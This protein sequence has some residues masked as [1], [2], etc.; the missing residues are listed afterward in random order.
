MP[1]PSIPEDMI[2]SATSYSIGDPGGVSRTEVA[3][4]LSRYALDWSRG[5][6]IFSV[7]MV[8]SDLQYQVWQYFY[9]HVIQKGAL[10]FLM[11]LDSDGTVVPHLVNILP[12][13]LNESRV[14]EVYWAVTYSV[15]AE[16]NAYNVS[17]DDAIAVI[18]FYNTYQDQSESFLNR[19]YTFARYD[20]EIVP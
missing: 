3:G 20:L 14:H 12:G 17:K 19:L 15:E 5:S 8:L 11:P 2:V 4:G 1:T 18:D 7:S 13:S 6:R 10:P 16:S 9:V